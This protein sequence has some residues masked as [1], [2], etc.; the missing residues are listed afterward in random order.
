M[1][2]SL[3]TIMGP[4]MRGSVRGEVVKGLKSHLSPREV[5]NLGNDSL[6]VCIYDYSFI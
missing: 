1:S 5:V 2:R 6:E 3:P 4:G